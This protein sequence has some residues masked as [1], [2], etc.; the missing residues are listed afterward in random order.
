MGAS[1]PAPGPFSLVRASSGR[2]RDSESREGVRRAARPSATVNE[3]S[4]QARPGREHQGPGMPMT[5]LADAM[6]TRR[7][8]DPARD[9]ACPA[10]YRGP[11]GVSAPVHG[12][13]GDSGPG[14]GER[15][16]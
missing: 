8:H 3:R 14:A 15:S 7:P 4:L 10:R 11:R 9:G 2:V 16:R 5:R 12:I 13:T 1:E 6:L